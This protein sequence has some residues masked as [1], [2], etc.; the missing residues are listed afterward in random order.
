MTSEVES[1]DQHRGN[2]CDRS[3]AALVLY[4][5]LFRHNLKWTDGFHRGIARVRDFSCRRSA[6]FEPQRPSPNMMANLTPSVNVKAR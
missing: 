4:A 2:L 5:G 1:R 6:G 3:S